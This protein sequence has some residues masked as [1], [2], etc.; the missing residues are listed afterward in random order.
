MKKKKLMLQSCHYFMITNISYMYSRS[1][2]LSL[3]TVH[4]MPNHHLKILV[5][6][7]SQSSHREK[8]N[9]LLSTYFL[10]SIHRFTQ[11]LQVGTFKLFIKCQHLNFNFSFFLLE[12]IMHIYIDIHVIVKKYMKIKKNILRH[13]N[14]FLSV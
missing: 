14:S 4:E 6:R 7:L 10:L 13:S 9:F 12:L 5:M 1:A 3:L 8:L 2:S 11:V